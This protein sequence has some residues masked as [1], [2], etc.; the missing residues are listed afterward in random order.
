MESKLK[1]RGGKRE[2]LFLII[3]KY[4]N[5]VYLYDRYENNRKSCSRLFTW[6]AGSKQ[7]LVISATES[8]SW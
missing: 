7:A 4:P 3:I 5:K 2:F 8:C 6:L 1:G